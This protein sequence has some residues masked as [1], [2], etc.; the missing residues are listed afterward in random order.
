MFLKQMKNESGSAVKE[1][2]PFSVGPQ[3]EEFE[4]LLLS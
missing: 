3:N 4:I 2:N 1:L